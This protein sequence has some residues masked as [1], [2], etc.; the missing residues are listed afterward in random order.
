MGITE[1]E[2]NPQTD[3]PLGHL[4]IPLLK[5]VVYRD[6]DERRWQQLLSAQIPVRDY[7]SVLG[8]ELYLDESEGHAFL[9]TPQSEEPGEESDLPRLVSRRRLTYGVSLLLALLRKRLAEFDATSSDT[10]L[11]MTRREIVD[12]VAVF[13]PSTTN[14]AKQQERVESDV[15]KIV[16]LGFLRPLQ[17]RARRTEEPRYEVRRI[18]KAFI[19]AQWMADFNDRL[20]EYRRA[21]TATADID[22]ADTEAADR[23]RDGDDG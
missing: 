1:L 16:D 18:L 6:T 20:D 22:T 17:T 15:A 11:V 13:Q 2:T 21:G 4:V 9:R 5:G 7:V 19:D 12:L 23:T 10:M 3:T 8:L 14:E